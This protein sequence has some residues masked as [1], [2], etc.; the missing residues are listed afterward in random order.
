MLNGE[1][2]NFQNKAV[3]NKQILIVT[4]KTTNIA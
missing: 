1:Q 4:I 2:S 3:M